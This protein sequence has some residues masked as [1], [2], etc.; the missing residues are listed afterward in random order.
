MMFPTE[1]VL[2]KVKAITS[3]KEALIYSISITVS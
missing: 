3:M 1:S 2:Q